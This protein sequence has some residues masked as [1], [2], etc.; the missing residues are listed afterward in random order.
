METFNRI[1][2]DVESI[3]EL[4]N[5]AEKVYPYTNLHGQRGSTEQEQRRRLTNFTNE[6]PDNLMRLGNSGMGLLFVYMMSRPGSKGLFDMSQ[7]FN[8]PARA[9]GW[10]LL[11][12]SILAFWRLQYAA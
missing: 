2:G 5:F 11:G 6:S 12:N 4:Y 9:F 3:L 10:F 1:N 7:I 8:R